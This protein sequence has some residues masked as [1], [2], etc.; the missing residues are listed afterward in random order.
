MRSTTLTLA[1]AMLVVVAAAGAPLTAVAAAQSAPAT[2]E[3]SGPD[4]VSPGETVTVE[5]A[6]SATETAP[7]Y[8][9]QFTLS[10]SSMVEGS[11]EKGG[12][13]AQDA[14]S[15]V[16]VGR[17]AG[18]IVEYGATRTGSEA[19]VTGEGTLAVLELTVPESTSA[20]ELVLEFDN[21]TVADAEAA[22]VDVAT[23]G[24]TIDVA[25][26]E[27]G[28][29]SGSRSGDDSDTDPATATTAPGG[30]T[31]TPAGT[32]TPDALPSVV[33]PAVVDR[34]DSAERVPVVVVLD[35]GTSPS[36]VAERLEERGATDVS[37]H[38][39]VNSVRATVTRS[40]LRP[41]VTDGVRSVRY[42]DS[43][44]SASTG[45]SAQS[46]DADPTSTAD[47][48]DSGEATGTSPPATGT[49]TTEFPVFSGPAVPMVAL[50]AGVA[51][52]RRRRRSDGR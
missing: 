27:S 51:L 46:P 1:V 12:Y 18:M 10:S 47:S 4:S 30:T 19:G 45:S 41:V 11:I 39:S 22:T 48:S 34:F 28:G 20:D 38:E 29:G 2:L 44:L 15:I 52:W 36:A 25:A 40:T 49:T 35:S 5:V 43:A 17:V 7:V 32:A 21:A 37:V 42:D 6:M 3:L 50:L 14:S 9:A 13:L 23:S 33:S 8:G 26:S 24:L 16:V 31:T